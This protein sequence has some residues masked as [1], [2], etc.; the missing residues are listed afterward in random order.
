MALGNEKVIQDDAQFFPSPWE[1]SDSSHLES[2]S[3]LPF[4]SS[5]FCPSISSQEAF[6]TPRQVLLLCFTELKCCDVQ[7][8]L[9]A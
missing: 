9:R 3:N 1:K 6:Q 2:V 8:G 4:I 5:S 7:E